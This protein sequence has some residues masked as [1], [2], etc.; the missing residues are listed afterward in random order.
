MPANGVGSRLGDNVGTVG[1]SLSARRRK[2]RH[3]LGSAKPA[4]LGWRFVSRLTELHREP[5]FEAGWAEARVGVA[6]RELAG[7]E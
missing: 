1:I 7:V 4:P 3:P 6:R 2:Y 5:F